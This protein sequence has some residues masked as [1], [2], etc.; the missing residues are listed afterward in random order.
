MPAR[1]R[2]PSTTSGSR[3][4]ARTIASSRRSRAPR[5]CRMRRDSSSTIGRIWRSTP[6]RS[7]NR[8]GCWRQSFCS[9]SRWPMRVPMPKPQRHPPLLRRRRRQS[10][11]PWP[12]VFHLLGP[13]RAESAPAFTRR[14]RHRAGLA[15]SCPTRAARGPCPGREARCERS[16][17]SCR[18][19]GAGDCRR[20]RQ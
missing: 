6:G 10:L 12:E 7:V 11:P 3:T 17:P 19:G 14:L 20:A 15:I 4:I 2:T 5:R 1:R 9:G 13:C 16:R 18:R 8:C